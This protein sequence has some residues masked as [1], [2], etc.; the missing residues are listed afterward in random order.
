MLSDNIDLNAA[1]VDRPH[2]SGS[3]SR[4]GLTGT[5]KRT[6]RS[7]NAIDNLNGTAERYTHNVKHWRG[8]EM[9]QRWVSAAPL[10]AGRYF[11]RV[12]GYRDMPPLLHA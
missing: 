6:L 11:R 3:F 10:E 5:L 1:I 8:G 7:I 9:I 12:R 2:R 4:L